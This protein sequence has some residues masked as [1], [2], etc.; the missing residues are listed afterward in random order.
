[1][2]M[3]LHFQALASG[4]KGNAILV[5]SHKTK[6]LIDAGLSAREL[7]SRLQRTSV[8]AGQLNAVVITHEHTD[9]VR[10]LGTLSRRFDLPVYLSQGT[11]ENLPLETGQLSE[12]NLFQPGVAFAIGDLRIHPFAVSHDAQ[13]PTGF[14]LE[15]DGRRLGVCTDLGIVTKLV[16]TRLQ[17]CHGLI[18]EANHDPQL[19]LNGPY[20]LPLKQRIRS[21][22]GHLSN[23]DSFELLQNI[24]HSALQVVLF[25]HLS[26]VNNQPDLVLTSA[27]EFLSDAAWNGVAFTVG[28]Q[29]EVSRTF[30]LI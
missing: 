12:V 24:Y 7:V 3:P 17:G 19:L 26:E 6:I 25:A 13:D 18:L 1:M 14:V 27:R 28:K 16:Q 23:I 5:S 29:H 22:H 30:E 2:P 10:G 21:R 4:S 11:L 15:H 20:P 8:K 9:H